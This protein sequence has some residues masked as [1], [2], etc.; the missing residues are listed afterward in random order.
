[1]SFLSFNIPLVLTLI[2]L[3]VSPLLV[4]LLFVVLLPISTF[5]SNCLLALVFAL[6]SLT[7]FFDGYL[8]RRYR[9][10]TIL[11]RVLDPIADKFLLYS[12]LIALVYVHKLYFYGAII[13]IGREF[14]IMG[15]REVSA[16]YGFELRVVS[17]AKLKTGVQ[18]VAII[19]LIVNPYQHLGIMQAPLCNSI[20]L[21]LLGLALYLSIM[22]AI[23]Y[24]A[25]FIKN[26]RG[27]NDFS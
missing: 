20:E 26:M 27:R 1:M 15:L 23:D 12:T 5:Y 3:I 4:P 6:L 18:M 25:L 11:G 10:E 8:A 21:L 7:D 9:K 16:S 13:C 24:C 2:R 22:S 19:Y 17:T 14:F